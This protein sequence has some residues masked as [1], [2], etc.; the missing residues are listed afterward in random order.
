MRITG[1]KVF[2][3]DLPIAGGE[4]HQ[5]GGRIWRSLDSTVVRIST[6]AGIVGWGESCP[7]GANYIPAFPQEVRGGIE[8]LAPDLIGQDPRNLQSLGRYMDTQLYGTPA[9]KTAIDNACWDILGKV[10]GL[11]VFTLLG[12]RT[13][14]DTPTTM[15]FFEINLGPPSEEAIR[16]AQSRGGDRFEF[17]ASGDPRTD[18]E[19]A[20]A[21][22]R[23]MKP[24]DTLKI[25]VNGGWRIDE[26]LRVAQ[27][28]NDI[29][30]LYEQPCSSYEECLAFKTAT[31]RPVSLDEC[32][33]GVRDLLRAIEDRAIDVLNLKIGRVGGLSK[34]KLLRDLCVAVGIPM[35]IQDTS[36]GEFNAAATA[37]LA[38]STP[39]GFIIAAWDCAIA[40]SKQIGYGLERNSPQQM[41][42][43]DVPGMGVEPDLDVLGEPVA[44]Y[45]D[46][47]K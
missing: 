35:Y 15:G 23:Y 39:P 6:D 47:R 27:A 10:T 22:G 14:E 2:Q 5:S 4:F 31:G 17:K 8:V 37:H 3:V 42:A 18:I 28:L 41:R 30:V 21:I 9:A 29:H 46:V 13:M 34:S 7:F 33:H 40:V 12:G 16:E 24:G 38:Q 44:V 26:A 11:P 45:G 19:M 1:I 32:I 43:P 36:G 25:D 20:R